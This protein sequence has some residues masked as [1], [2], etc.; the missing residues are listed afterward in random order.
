[1]LFYCKYS[2]FH[3]LNNPFLMSGKN[4]CNESSNLSSNVLEQTILLLAQLKT[5]PPKLIYVYILNFTLVYH[6]YL[7]DIDSN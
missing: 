7:L 3:F 4:S 6:L 2:F 5:T 1:M